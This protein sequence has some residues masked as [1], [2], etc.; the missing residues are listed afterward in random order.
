[1]SS[2]KIAAVTSQLVVFSLGDEEYALPITD[3]QEIIRY[4]EPR[5]VASEAPWIRGV[6]SLR[7]K[8][9]PVCDLAARLG[10]SADGERRANIVI[11]E[12]ANGTAGVIVDDVEEVLTVDESQ[13]DA[14]P[15]AGT[16]FIEG[17]AKVDDR[18]IVLLNPNGIFAGVEMADAA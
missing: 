16:D 13:L 15:S 11:V 10:L 2:S 17:V 9:I 18:L 5:A 6:I 3:V 12:T 4:A 14:V 1:M 7:G 8:I